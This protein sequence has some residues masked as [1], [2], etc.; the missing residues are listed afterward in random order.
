MDWYSLFGKTVVPF[1]THVSSG[2]GDTVEKI[3]NLI[4]EAKV[5]QGIAI[6]E[7]SL[8][9]DNIDETLKEQLGEYIVE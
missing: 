4:P 2:L 5:F 8:D 9:N 3:Q 7:N 6:Q 1:T